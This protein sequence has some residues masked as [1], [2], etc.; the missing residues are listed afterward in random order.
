MAR[1]GCSTETALQLFHNRIYSTS[2]E[3]KPILL[4]VPL[5]LSAAFDMINHIVLLKRFTGSFGVTGTVLSWIQSYLS[6]RIHS[7]SLRIDTHT[8]QL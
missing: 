2:D 7:V 3:S 4:V 5:D 6:G 8:R 1:S